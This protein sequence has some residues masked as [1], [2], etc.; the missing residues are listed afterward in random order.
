MEKCKRTLNT[1]KIY[2][3]LTSIFVVLL[4]CIMFFAIRIRGSSIKST[5][6]LMDMIDI[7]Y[8]KEYNQS[9]NL[10]GYIVRLKYGMYSEKIKAGKCIF[11]IEN[12]NGTMEGLYFVYGNQLRYF[13]NNIS[14]CLNGTGNICSRAELNNGKLL[15]YTEFGINGYLAEEAMERQGAYQIYLDCPSKAEEC[16]KGLYGINLEDNIGAEVYKTGDGTVIN[17][18]SVGIAIESEKELG[19]YKIEIE[20]KNNNK[21]TVYNKGKEKYEVIS[22]GRVSVKE[23]DV[24]GKTDIPGSYSQRYLGF[25]GRNEKYFYVYRYKKAY[26][27]SNI[28]QVYINGE[29]I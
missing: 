7:N 13:G 4:A 12:E 14:I 21:K 16:A 22:G 1:Y 27:A 20:D 29:K 6:S 24:F 28:K 2:F 26:N 23:N 18:S 19:K 25:F 11:E 5:K 3:I 8:C 17:I 10:N 9:Y 15:V